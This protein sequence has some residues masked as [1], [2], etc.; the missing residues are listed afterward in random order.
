MIEN[1][2]NLNSLDGVEP[3]TVI[4]AGEEYKAR[5]KAVKMLQKILAPLV[6]FRQKRDPSV[7][8]F[9]KAK[10]TFGL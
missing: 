8:E 3:L 9:I 5:Y 2:D 7:D 1:I 6:E 4:E 10:Q